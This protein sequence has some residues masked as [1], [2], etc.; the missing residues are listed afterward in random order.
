MK[1]SSSTAAGRSFLSRIGHLLT[2]IFS[3][4]TNK[5]SECHQTL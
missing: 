5:E 2:A 4:V 1:D 3:L